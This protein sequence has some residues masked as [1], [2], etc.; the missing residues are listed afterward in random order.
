MSL[1]EIFVR[2]PEDIQAALEAELMAAAIRGTVTPDTVRRAAREI[3]ENLRYHPSA[4]HEVRELL[5]RVP[6]AVIDTLF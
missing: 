1:A 5:E 6:D 2:L 3:T 4:T